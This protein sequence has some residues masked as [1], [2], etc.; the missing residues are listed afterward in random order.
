[1]YGVSRRQPSSFRNDPLLCCLRSHVP[2]IGWDSGVV[3][4]L[5]SGE[6]VVCKGWSPSFMSSVVDQ[7]LDD[8]FP[9]PPSS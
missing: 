2:K 1:M 5:V 8:P 4:I 9:R 6:L 7:S 3:V